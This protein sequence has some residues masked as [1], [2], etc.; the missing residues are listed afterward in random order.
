M[1]AMDVQP[2]MAST[3]RR[4]FLGLGIASL[5]FALAFLPAPLAVLYEL[6]D[7][8]LRMTSWSSGFS[9]W[10]TLVRLPPI[11]VSRYP[12]LLVRTA[13][14]AAIPATLLLGVAAFASFRSRRWSI[15]LHAL[16]VPI[17]LILMTVLLIGAHRFSTALDA[18]AAS[19]DLAMRL[20]YHSNVRTTAVLIA[21]PG[22]AYPFVLVFAYWLY[23]LSKTRRPAR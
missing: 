3:P 7:E 15:R 21:I 4:G 18:A 14:I 5:V 12:Y 13:V 1:N 19:R 23:G 22:I 11:P 9:T 2:P 8:C 10:Q 16:Y 17:Q 6:N 20:P